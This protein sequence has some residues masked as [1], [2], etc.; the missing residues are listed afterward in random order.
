MGKVDRVDAGENAFRAFFMVV[1]RRYR[2]V[3]AVEGDPLESLAGAQCDD[4][5]DAAVHVDR[6]LKAGCE[7][8]LLAESKGG[9]QNDRASSNSSHRG[10]T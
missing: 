7:H 8:G 10:A 9:Q 5:D 6:G 1:S 3:L 4:A 2:S